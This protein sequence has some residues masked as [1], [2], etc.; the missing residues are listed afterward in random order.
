[1]HRRPRLSLDLLKS[2]E[3]AARHV[4]FTR[5]A[6]ELFVTQSAVSRGI[7]T[8]EEQ[9]GQPLF[10]RVSR[11]LELTDAGR[12]LQHAVGDALRR[13][14]EAVDGLGTPT[15]PGSP[16]PRTCR[17]LPCGWRRACRSLP[18]STRTS[19]CASPP[20]TT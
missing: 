11:G 4:S 9:L 17:S 3:A 13:I 15:R 18:D 7:K 6:Q 10:R 14:E 1:M 2:F 19:T 5:A 8:L 16:S 20:A 12:T